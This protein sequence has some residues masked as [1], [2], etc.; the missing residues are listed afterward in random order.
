MRLTWM[1]GPRRPASRAAATLLTIVTVA[2][3]TAA[4]AGIGYTAA[5]PLLDDGS[6]F[7]SKGHEVAHVNGETRKADAETAMRLATGKEQLQTVRL[8]DGRLVVVNKTT[9]VVSY[10][11]AATLT[12]DAKP[13]DP[14]PSGGKI[15]PVPTDSDGYLVD[16]ERGTVAKITLPGKPAPEPV[17]V[18]DGISEA[19]PCAD[20]VWVVTGNHEIVEIVDGRQV[21]RVRLGAPLLGVTVADSHPVAVTEDGTAYLVDGEE[22]RAVGKLGVSGPAVRLGSWSGAGRQILAV[23]SKRHQLAVLDP[24][25]GRGFTL[26]LEAGP[27]AELAAP[28]MLGG[29]AYVPD[30]SGPKLW[31]IDLGRGKVA[32]K[33]MDVPG[34]RGYFELKVTGG[35]VWA[36]N[37]YDRRVLIV[38]ATGQQD[39]ADKGAA[40]ELTDTE[41]KTGPTDEKPDGG[42]KNPPP[43]PAPATQ[44]PPSGGGGRTVTVPSFPRGT[45]YQQACDRLAALGL[46]CRPVAVGDDESSRG[47]GEVLSTRPAAGRRVPVPS[48]VVVR[49]VGPLRTP[50]VVGSFH[51]E[52]CRQITSARLRCVETTTADPALAPEQ[53]GL[54]TAQDPPAN[55]EIDRNAPVTIT[56]RDSIALPS[57]AGQAFGDVCDRLE[58][59]YRMTCQAVAGAPATGG[60]SAGQVHAQEPGAGTVVRMGATITIRYYVGETAVASV[61]GANIDAACA[62]VEAQGHLCVRTEGQCAWGTGHPVG[63]VYAQN[64][65]PGGQQPVGT[66]VTLTYY[67]D[68]CPLGDY[69]GQSAEAACQAINASGFT[70]NLVA[71]LHPTPGVVIDQNPAGGAPPLGSRVDVAYAPWVPIATALHGAAYPVGTAIPA[72]RVIYHYTCDAG[73]NRCRGLPRNEFFSALPPGSPTIDADF[74]GVPYATL[75][76]CGSA[77]GQKRVWRTWNAGSPRYY[78]HVLSEGR[79]AAD[80]SEELGCV[81]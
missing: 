1:R 56:Y 28:V 64:P 11:D 65:A 7:L 30:Y 20:S 53:L 36:N 74:R 33:P 52:A 51:T 38:S 41:G 81:W 34:Q 35:R 6:A 8:P 21:R 5:R 47:P 27:Q 3:T 19:V 48:A 79:P 80:D 42:T 16:R 29:F 14:Q 76:T 31:K 60:Q 55:T 45:S 62:A 37:Q 68:K 12:L 71:V 9:G 69:R 24:R 49:Y 61:V 70:C 66:H 54:V 15:E 25:T 2:G 22:P 50:S 59:Q 72:P 17:H 77:P 63:E 39:Y 75:M 40:P 23:D 32:G 13:G 4:A 10:L 46:R 67:S 26:E 57:F 73:G 58:R 18:E 78:Q 44:A 43:G